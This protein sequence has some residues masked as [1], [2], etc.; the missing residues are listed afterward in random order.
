MMNSA[1]EILKL[2]MSMERQGQR[3]YE[4]FVNQVESPVIKEI[5]LSLSKTEEEHY[6][7]LKN[8]LDKLVSGGHWSPID[9]LKPAIERSLF[10]I[11]LEAEKLNPENLSMSHSDISLLRMAYLIENDFAEYYKKAMDY[12]QDE[13]GKKVLEMLY[14]WENEHRRV[15]YDEYKKAMDNYWFDQSFSPF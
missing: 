15:F 7:I 6:L 10:D 14:H 4:G 1:I 12:T 5:F 13:N 8:Q 2:A 3:F 9:Q 11:R